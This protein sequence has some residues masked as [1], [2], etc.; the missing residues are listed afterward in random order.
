MEALHC[1]FVYSIPLKPPSRSSF[2]NP[3][4]KRP[5]LSCS[6]R[7]DPWTLSDGNDKNLNKPKPRHKNPKNPLSDD[8]ARRIIKGKA[9]YLSA[10]RRNLGSQVQTP[11]WIKRTPE[12]ML[13]YLE[14]DRN[15]RLYGKHV[16]AAINVV[17][18]LSSKPQGSYD[19][20]KVMGSFVAKFTFR[21][22]CIVLKEQ[23][24]WRQVRDFFSWMK[25]QLSYQPSVIAYTIVLRAY[26]QVGKI[27]LAEQTFLEMLEAG[28]EPDEVACCTML[29]AYAKWGCHK[30]MMALFSAVQQRGITLPTSVFNFM[31]SSLQKKNLHENVILIWKN[32]VNT[33]VH[34]NHF[35]YTVV[36]PS[37]VKGGLA[38]E[39][40]TTFNEM[41]TLGFVPGEATYS[42]LISFHSKSGSHNESFD[43]YNE[44]RSQGI[45]PSNFTCASL[46][47]ACYKNEDYSKALSLFAEMKEY[48]ITTDEVIYGLLIRIYG[49][50]GL[51]QDAQ[52]TFDEIEKLGILSDEKTYTT[53]AQV[54]LGA[55][56]VEKA[57]KLIELMKSKGILCSRFAYSVLLHCNVIK[58]DLPS[59]ELT[60]SDLSKVELPDSVSCYAMLNLYMR[61]GLYEKAKDFILQMRKYQLEFDEQLLKTVLK[62]Y[63][64][65][66][67]VRDTEKLLEELST[68]KMFEDSKLCQTL[69]MTTWG[70]WDGLAEVENALKPLDQDGSMALKLS[71]TLML[72]DGNTVKAQ[73]ILLI[74]LKAAN[75]LSIASQVLKSFAT[76]GDMSK[77]ENLLELLMKLGCKPEESATA[78]MIYLCGKQHKL[79]QA[80]KIFAAVADS[81]RNLTLLY[82]SMIDAYTRCNEQHEAYLFYKEEF[83]KGHAMSPVATSMLVNALT[84]YAKYKEAEDVIHSTFDANFELDTVAYNTFIKAMLLAGKLHSA[85]SIYDRMVS[86]KINPSIQTYSTMI[87]VYGRG[88]NLDKAV[89]MFNIARSRGVPLDEKAYT[90]MISYYGKARKVHEASTLFSKMQEEGIKPGHLCYSIMINAYAFAG[91]YHEAEEVYHSMRRDGFQPNSTTYLALTRAYSVGSAFNKA[92]KAIASMQKEGIALSCAHF[93]VLLTVLAKEGLVEECERIFGELGK[94]GLQPN[95]QC[96]RSM[97]RGYMESGRVEEGISFFE[98]I[99]G[100]VETDKFIMSVALHLYRSVGMELKARE[101]LR[102]MTCLGIQVLKNLEVGAKSRHLLAP[103]KRIY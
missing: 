5:K 90:N 75:G 53:M 8:N 61:R 100:S 7:P 24:G 99:R 19:M 56:N 38:E 55:G 11:K 57:L 89:E 41:K 73:E 42:L 9:R 35:T 62:V 81:T 36:I 28:C 101:V 102:S 63:C 40:L 20:R 59:A 88:R 23:K 58:G 54:H 21:E 31:I 14:D 71:L 52:D 69:L 46:L 64:K 25:M 66:G 83:K 1:S 29:C 4:F 93:N 68:S 91:S 80:E 18:S 82:D 103:T 92:E 3:K 34:P 78:H 30:A 37:L 96:N 44:M 65:E 6:L 45:I 85:V 84:N 47:T 50:L 2:K 33:H 17:R 86:L 32:M 12:Q 16:I 70:T 48:K 15:G 13:Q 79:R 60:F 94:A 43:L 67:M 27:E 10:L 77:A 74:L 95:V 72:A 39:A 98:R 87:S 76:E 22:M 49:K 97:L 51:Y 26:S